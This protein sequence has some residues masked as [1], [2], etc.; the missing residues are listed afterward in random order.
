MGEVLRVLS[1]LA[2]ET[3]VHHLAADSDLDRFVFRGTATVLDYRNY[4]S[5][6]YGFVEPVELALAQT[7]D[8][9]SVIDLAPR[10][11]GARLHQDL[12]GLGLTG[13]EID[14]LPRCSGV[15][16][17]ESVAVALGWLYVVERPTLA[18]GVVRGHL[19]TQLHTEMQHAASYLSCYDGQTGSMW[20][21]L[22]R[23]MERAATSTAVADRI[24]LAAHEAFRCL[25]RW[26]T[27]GAT[28][29][30]AQRYAS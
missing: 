8:F 2:E 4:L 23:A 6:V 25:E 3:Q 22:G 19:D 7:I 10:L 28:A 15:P 11:K 26:L 14:D 27:A 12:A 24:V 18:N 5:R 29:A 30:D 16:R 9:A 21:D 1:R 13:R 17:I 20:R